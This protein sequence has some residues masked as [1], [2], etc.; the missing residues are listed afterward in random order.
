MVD[1][2]E[3]HIDD[4][5]DNEA[6]QQAPSTAS[7]LITNEGVGGE[8]AGNSASAHVQSTGGQPSVQNQ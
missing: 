5:E 3:G 7:L 6:P 4:L 2:P 1:V 8:R